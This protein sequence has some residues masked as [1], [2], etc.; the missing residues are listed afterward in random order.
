MADALEDSERQGG[1]PW[2]PTWPMSYAP[3]SPTSRG[4]IEAMQDGL[5]TPDAANLDAV[6][7]QTLY[8]NH[9]VSDLRLLAETEANELS[10]DMK[11]TADWRHCE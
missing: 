10:L 1:A 8:L 5:L 9:L 11:P 3:R 6:H 7:Q 2:Y 4:H